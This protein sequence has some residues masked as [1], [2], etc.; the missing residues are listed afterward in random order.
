[1]HSLL[2]S[3]LLSSG[4]HSP[5]AVKSCGDWRNRLKSI[6]ALITPLVESQ[7]AE[8]ASELVLLGCSE[9]PHCNDEE[10]LCDLRVWYSHVTFKMIQVVVGPFTHHSAAEAVG[11]EFGRLKETKKMGW[12]HCNRNGNF[13]G[14]RFT[15][16]A[17]TGFLLL[18]F[19]CKRE[20]IGSFL[21]V[22]QRP[23]TVLLCFRLVSPSRL[24]VS[25]WQTP[26]GSDVCRRRRSAGTISLQTT[27]TKSPTRTSFQHFFTNAI[28]LLQLEPKHPG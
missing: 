23:D 10:G 19:T 7:S 1:M 26:L 5:S 27:F 12:C 22:A 6:T 14:A 4:Q 3:F 13:S 28:S 8:S 17:Q 16:G 25:M 9:R 18:R 24:A 20:D 2:A 11:F 21:T 15:V